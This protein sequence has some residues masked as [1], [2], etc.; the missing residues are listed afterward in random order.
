MK[1][2]GVSSPKKLLLFSQNLRHRLITKTRQRMYARCIYLSLGVF[3]V[4]IRKKCFQLLIISRNQSF[5]RLLPVN[6]VGWKDTKRGLAF[7]F[8]L[9]L[10]SLKDWTYSAENR[11]D[12]YFPNSRTIARNLQ[13]NTMDLFLTDIILRAKILSFPIILPKKS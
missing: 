11:P 1:T 3:I 5:F 2:I 12:K 7:C 8:I 6:C 9:M 13:I 10:F 4:S